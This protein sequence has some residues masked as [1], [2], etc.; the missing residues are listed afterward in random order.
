MRGARSRALGWMRAVADVSSGSLA[1]EAA[2]TVVT[3]QGSCPGVVTSAGEHSGDRTGPR[4]S[5]GA[6]HC[7][8]YR[9]RSLLPVRQFSW[10]DERRPRAGAGDSCRSLSGRARAR[11]ADRPSL[12][13]GPS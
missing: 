5:R 2:S 12:R 10:S 4:A 1:E 3:E 9:A 11:A 13:V 7:G 8:G 6:P